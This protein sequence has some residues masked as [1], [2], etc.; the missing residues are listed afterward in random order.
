MFDL[1]SDQ[2]RQ[3]LVRLSVRHHEQLFSHQQREQQ[4][5]VALQECTLLLEQSVSI[6]NEIA[7]SQTPLTMID[8]SRKFKAIISLTTEEEAANI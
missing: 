6:I 7:P 8:A 2:L 3:R 1:F 5:A 4:L